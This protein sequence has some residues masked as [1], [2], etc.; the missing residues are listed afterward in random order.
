MTVPTELA[1]VFKSHAHCGIFKIW[2]AHFEGFLL[3]QGSFTAGYIWG[4]GGGQQQAACLQSL[5]SKEQDTSQTCLSHREKGR[6]KGKKHLRRKKKIGAHHWFFILLS[7][8]SLIH[9][10]KNS[11]LRMSD[12]CRVP[13]WLTSWVPQKTAFTTIYYLLHKLHFFITLLL[14][15]SNMIK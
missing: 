15:W 6:S 5:W 14:L 10:H 3:T 13:T 9:W 4:W 2:N 12:E 1:A 7:V 8:N 11:H